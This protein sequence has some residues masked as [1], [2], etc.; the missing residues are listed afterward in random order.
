MSASDGSSRNSKYWCETSIEMLEPERFRTWLVY[1][2][3]QITSED[4]R[5]RAPTTQ[6]A[7]THNTQGGDI[8]NPEVFL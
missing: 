3:E 5:V 1:F 6:H 2:F 4:V 8:K 7:P